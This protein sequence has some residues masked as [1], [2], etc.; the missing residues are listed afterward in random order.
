[1]KMILGVVGAFVVLSVFV[2]LSLGIRYYTANLR[3]KVDAQERR[4]S[5]PMRLAAYNYF[6]DLCVAVQGHEA[7]LDALHRELDVTNDT[8]E[9]VRIRTNITGLES[10][11]SRSI[12]Q[13]NQ[14]ARKD[15]TIG[16]FRDTDLPY[17]I[18]P[19]E[20]TKGVKTICAY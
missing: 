5:G 7:S 6:F 4:L 10:Y 16:Q 19:V 1:M 13:Y 18:P 17:Q 14:D 20:Y 11:R 2:S 8:K 15:Y 9:Q 3:G 12:A